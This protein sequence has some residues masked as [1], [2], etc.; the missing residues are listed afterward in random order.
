MK[1]VSTISSR[2]TSLDAGALGY[3]YALANVLILFKRGKRSESSA[4]CISVFEEREF[5]HVHEDTV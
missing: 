3:V 4:S 1:S 2:L 5:M